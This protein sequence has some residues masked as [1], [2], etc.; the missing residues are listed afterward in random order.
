[1]IGGRA[2]FFT[3]FTHRVFCCQLKSSVFRRTVS[4]GVVK[5]GGR[6]LAV[7]DVLVAE[8][9]NTCSERV[10]VTQHIEASAVGAED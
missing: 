5:T 8:L 10:D 1:M 2:V 7:D 4:K 6:H 9:P 3:F